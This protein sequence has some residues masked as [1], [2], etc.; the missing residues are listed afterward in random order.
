MRSIE[1]PAPEATH[2]I[3]AVMNTRLHQIGTDFEQQLRARLGPPEQPPESGALGNGATRSARN[4]HSR[5]HR[6]R[7]RR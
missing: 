6:K 2:R 1:D 5:R 7:R 3:D 4:G